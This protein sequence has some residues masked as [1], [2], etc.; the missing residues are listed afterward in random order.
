MVKFTVRPS[1]PLDEMFLEK[2][3]PLT[4]HVE[5]LVLDGGESLAEKAA[6]ALEALVAAQGVPPVPTAE[7]AVDVDR[8]S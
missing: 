5:G 8:E 3:P 1:T 4:P 6:A 7:G 2:P